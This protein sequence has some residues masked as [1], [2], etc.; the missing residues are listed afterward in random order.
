MEPGARAPAPTPL[1]LVQAF[2]N[3]VDL[4]DGA[5]RLATPAD[6]GE[7]LAEHGLLAPDARPARMDLTRA[8]ALR[9]A[10][11]DLVAAHNDLPA[12]AAA[13]RAVL[14][15]AGARGRL[16][17]ALDEH[18]RAVLGAHAPGVDGALGSVVAA[19]HTAAVDGTW[20]RLKACE[21]GH[22]R[23]AFYDA[24]RNRSSRWCS[25][26]VCGAREKARRAYHRER[27]RASPGT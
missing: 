24:S 20:P 18:D 10:L 4:D 27:K 11:R 26:A 25:M 15:H 7:W 13:A 19:V 14:E 17:F 5:D 1:R 9:G 12:D 16:R 3:T 6:L 22:C 2:A 21:R 23:W 8:L